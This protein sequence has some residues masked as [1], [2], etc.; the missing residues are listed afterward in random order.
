M[1]LRCNCIVGLISSRF[2]DTPLTGRRMQ[3]FRKLV[4]ILKTTNIIKA[5]EPPVF[6][7]FQAPFFH[8][9]VFKTE[10]SICCFP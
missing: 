6:V 1:D 7:G 3:L 2:I 4:C 5:G 9:C 10:Q 8:R